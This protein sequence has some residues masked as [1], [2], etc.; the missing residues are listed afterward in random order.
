MAT[1]N[2][3]TTIAIAENPENDQEIATLTVNERKVGETFTYSLGECL[4]DVVPTIEDGLI[5]FRHA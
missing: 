5:G 3:S 1:I 4:D 2:I